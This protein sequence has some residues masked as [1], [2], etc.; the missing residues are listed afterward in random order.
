MTIEKHKCFALDSVLPRYVIR[1]IIYGNDNKASFKENRNQSG[2]FLSLPK[3]WLDIS[4][5]SSIP[6]SLSSV[7]ERYNACIADDNDSYSPGWSNFYIQLFSNISMPLLLP[8]ERN[9]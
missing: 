5:C 1:F 6:T 4:V 2:P 3:R 9:T 7:R 8:T